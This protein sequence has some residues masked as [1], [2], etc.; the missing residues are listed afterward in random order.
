[1]CKREYEAAEVEYGAAPELAPSD[2]DVRARLG[3]AVLE[4]GRSREA[5]AAAPRFATS[6]SML[7]FVQRRAGDE[8]AAK[9]AIHNYL[10]A[11]PN[12]TIARFE[13]GRLPS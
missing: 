7:G 9:A 2:A 5:V 3:Q 1:M 13:C 12:L 6:H 11:G 8:E 10:E 4:L